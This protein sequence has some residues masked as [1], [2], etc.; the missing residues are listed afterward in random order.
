MSEHA[1]LTWIQDSGLGQY[2]KTSQYPFSVCESLHF[3]GLCVLIGAMLVVDLR[4]LGVLKGISVRATMRLVPVAI[5]G[6]AINLVSGIALFSSEPFNYW[7]NPAFKLK[8]VL[9]LLAGANALWHEFMCKARVCA[10][11]DDAE[12]DTGAKVVAGLSLLLWA[13]VI[14]L[15]RLLP[16]FTVN[17]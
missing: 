3:I 15:G 2:V 16:Q 8:M 13:G 10:L 11:G 9:I 6:F 14:V 1:I 5:A 7:Y 12:A 17:G 4:L